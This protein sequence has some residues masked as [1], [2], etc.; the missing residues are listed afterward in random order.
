MGQRMYAEQHEEQT[1]PTLCACECGAALQTGAPGS[2]A[3]FGVCLGRQRVREGVG[4][5]GR[6]RQCKNMRRW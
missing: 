6:Q 2:D 3:R 5:T 1:H 4:T